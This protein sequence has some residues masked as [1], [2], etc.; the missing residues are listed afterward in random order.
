MVDAVDGTGPGYS[1]PAR[2]SPAGALQSALAAGDEHPDPRDGQSLW[3]T[4][5]VSSTEARQGYT[6]AHVRVGLIIAVAMGAMNLLAYAYTIAV[7]HTIGR[8]AFGAFAALLGVLLVI[9]VVSLGLQATGARRISTSPDAGLTMEPVIL[10]VGLRS[11]VALGALTAALAP[12]LNVILQL[13]SLATAMLIPLAA[14]PLTY[15][16]AQAGVLQGERRWI[17][18]GLVYV[19]QGAGRFGIG[20][21]LV[22]VWPTEFAAVLGVALGAWLPVVIAAVALRHRRAGR[23]I[24]AGGHPRIDLIR[25]VAHSSQALLAFFV[26]SN[27]DILVARASMSESEAG[28]YAGG[29][30]LVK[31]VL[32]LPQ[33]VVVI[34]FPTMASKGASRRNLLLALG[35]GGAIGIIGSLAVL[36]LPDLALLFIGGDDFAEIQPHLWKFAVVGT[37]LSMIQ[38]LVYSVLARQHRRAMI[39][40]WAGLGALVIVALTADQASTLVLVVMFVDAALFA[41]LL[42]PSLR[43]PPLAG[44]VKA[45]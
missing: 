7:A 6:S 28:L 23:S 26:L 35:L 11:A 45:P 10:S 1:T 2:R 29:L 8:Q 39:I 3:Q 13:D 16:G 31:A 43:K 37:I 24:T 21:A 40:A 32:F 42:V 36:V 18:L 5:A 30:I 44:S 33:F 22:L 38:I 27:V 4:R 14:V 15:M 17:P 20:L 25:E 19:A 41:A 34:A 12:V 9:N